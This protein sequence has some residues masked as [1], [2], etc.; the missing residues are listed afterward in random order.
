MLGDLALIWVGLILAILL[1]TEFNWDKSLEYL[2]QETWFFVGLSVTTVLVFSMR[3]LYHRAWRYVGIGDALDLL[4]A[5]AISLIP[6]QLLALSASGIAF[7]RSGVPL[8]FFPIFFL[9]SGFRLAV[10]VGSESRDRRSDGKRYLIVGWNDAA[11]IAVRELQRSG[12]EAVGLVSVSAAS[13]K[14]DIRG[15]PH[16]GSLETVEELIKNKGVN[17]LVLAGLTPAENGRVMKSVSGLNIELRTIPPVSELLKGELQVATLRPLQLE[18]LLEREPVRFDVAKVTA[19]LRGERILVTGAGGSIGSEIV[20]QCLRSGPELVVLFGRGENSIHEI[21]LEVQRALAG[22]SGPKLVPFIGNVADPNALAAVFN[23]YQPTVVFH[24]AAHKHVPLMEAR[25]VEACANNILG[26]LNLM[27]FCQQHKVKKLVALST[28]KAV[29][30]SSVMGATKRVTELLLHTSGTPG[31]AAV[32]FGNV[33]GSRGSVIPTLQA[34]IAQ[35]GPVTVTSADME[36]YFMT[37]PEAVSLVL[38]AGA[39]ASGGEIYVLEMGAPVRILDLAENLIRLSGMVPHQDIEIT[40]SGIRPGEKLIEA[41]VDEGEASAPSGWAGIM[42]VD[43]TRLSPSWP[44]EGLERLRLAVE[45]GDDESA[46]RFL[47]DL[48]KT[49]SNG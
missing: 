18:D 10:R 23:T 42:R 26:T 30:P 11:E 20:R 12:G 41:L 6:F 27:R 1:R 36:R 32:R 7:P 17:G 34:Q 19:Y 40:F 47:F 45:R 4:V 2:N 29:A 22:Q 15:C 31:F 28:D 33:L 49:E 3:G 38:G 37:I 44:G 48:L 9:L 13:S 46:R 43:P 16:L 8:A 25:P 35:G 39:M 14:L 21:T 24:A 5:L